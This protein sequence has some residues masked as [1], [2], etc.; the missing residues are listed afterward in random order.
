[1]PQTTAEDKSVVQWCSKVAT[2]NASSI[3]LVIISLF[4]AFGRRE[5]EVEEAKK[6]G[7]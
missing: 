6:E 4:F 7:V 5:E 2:P 1:M 3:E